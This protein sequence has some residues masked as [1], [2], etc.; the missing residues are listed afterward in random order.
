LA[1]QKNQDKNIND[2]VPQVEEVHILRPQRKIR[3]HRFFS[4]LDEE[5]S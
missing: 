4:F 5:E 1:Q 3:R 2:Y